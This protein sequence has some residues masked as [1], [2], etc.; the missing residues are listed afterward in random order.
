MGAAER[1]KPSREERINAAMAEVTAA[2][3]RLFDLS[4][5]EPDFYSQ[6]TP[7]PGMK[8]RTYLEHC[9]KRSW[10][11]RKIGRLRVTSR[12]DFKTW[13]GS[14]RRYEAR[15]R[16]APKIEHVEDE[17]EWLRTAGGRRG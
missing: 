11:S 7:P 17:A 4:R 2:L 1:L 9:Y 6:D 14:A 8:P 13:E 3:R 5:E 12:E 15:E 10:P 16:E